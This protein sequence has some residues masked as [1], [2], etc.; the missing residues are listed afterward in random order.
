ML[1]CSEYLPIRT[2]LS[3]NYTVELIKV[4]SSLYIKH[5]WL[6]CTIVWFWHLISSQN[7]TLLS[8]STSDRS[9]SIWT[10]SPTSTSNNR[11]LP[12]NMVLYEVINI[13]LRCPEWVE[14]SIRVRRL[15]GHRQKLQV[16]LNDNSLGSL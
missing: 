4:E 2:V 9:W 12:V 11:H 7:S 15:Q 6:N 13:V 16:N 5:C 10:Y 1:W 3:V 8:I 14:I